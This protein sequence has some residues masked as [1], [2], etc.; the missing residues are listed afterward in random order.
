MKMKKINKNVRLYAV[1]STFRTSWKGLI[2]FH[3]IGPI[4]PFAIFENRRQAE[5]YRDGRNDYKV[6]QIIIKT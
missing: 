5:I 2:R 1:F 3:P 6:K 4:A